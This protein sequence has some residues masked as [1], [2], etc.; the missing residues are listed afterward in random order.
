MEKKTQKFPAR[1]Q[2]PSPLSTKLFSNGSAQEEPS[3]EEVELIGDAGPVT[4]SRKGLKLI[5]PCF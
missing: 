3:S 5:D 2:Q 4:R 1:H